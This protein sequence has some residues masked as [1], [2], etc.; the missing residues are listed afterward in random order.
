MNSREAAGLREREPDLQV[1][2]RQQAGGALGPLHDAERI[3][4]EVLPE[5]CILP[6]L[7]LLETIKIKV[8][9]VYA[10]KVIN[11]NQRIGRALCAARMAKRVDE[12]ARERG[13]ARA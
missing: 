4:R 1:R 6:F 13:L 8:I 9:Q 3:R 11:F 7:I 10:R 12:A 5:S 2:R